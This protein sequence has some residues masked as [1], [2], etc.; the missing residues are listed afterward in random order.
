MG[1]GVR[2][3]PSPLAA[4]SDAGEAI[5]A[6]QPCDALLAD[7]NTEPEPQLGQHPRRPVGSARVAVNLPNGHRERLVRDRA[8]RW[9]P[10]RPL[11]VARRR[12]LQEPA[13][14]RDRDSVGGKLLDQP[15]P[16][17]GSTFSLAK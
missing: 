11:V 4:V 2:L 1:G 7:M 12:D 14:H 8:R 13:G 15:E 17:F 9:W 16:Y 10:G 3:P 6:H 5:Q